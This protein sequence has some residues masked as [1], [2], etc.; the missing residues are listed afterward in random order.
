MTQLCWASKE[1]DSTCAFGGGFDGF[2]W[3]ITKLVWWWFWM[4][5]WPKFLSSSTC[6]NHSIS[7]SLIVFSV[8]Y[9]WYIFFLHLK[10]QFS[11]LLFSC[12]DNSRGHVCVAQ[13]G[14]LYISEASLNII[15][16][17]IKKL[18]RLNT[19]FQWKFS[20]LIKKSCIQVVALL[21]RNRNI[22]HKF[23]MAIAFGVNV[24]CPA[25]WKQHPWKE[26]TLSLFI[27]WAT[28]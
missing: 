1:Q 19:L 20:V 6:R 21:W 8:I 18:W 16:F 7:A 27:L 14:L 22:L 11:S 25:D 9:V 10:R 24:L 17:L 23:S 3:C 12:V 2:D 4:G 13:K 28:D 5:F 15:F 26:G